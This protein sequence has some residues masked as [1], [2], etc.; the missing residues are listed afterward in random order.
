MSVTLIAHLLTATSHPMF[1]DEFYYLDCASHPDWGYVDQPPVSIMS[2][3]GW[4]AIAGDSL[5]A[6][7][8]L[9]SLAAAALIFL[10]WKLTAELGG[11]VF[12]CALAGL[13]SL[14]S[15]QQ[16][17]IMGLYSMNAFDLLFWA[18]AFWIIIRLIKTDNRRLWIPFGIV[19]GLGLMNKIGLLFLGAGLVVA[20]VVT[21]LRR[22]FRHWQFWAGGVLAFL[23]FAPY[24]VWQFSHDFATVEF[25]R[26]ASA[27]KNVAF[28]PHQFLIEFALE[29][30]PLT[31]LIWVSGLAVL[32]FWS[33]L[34][35]FRV[36]GWTALAVFVI[37][38]AQH[39]KPYYAA[40]LLSLLLATGS[41]WIEHI[42]QVRHWIRVVG[43]SLLIAGGI[44]LLPM[45]LRI[46]TPQQFISYQNTL[47]PPMQ[48][49]ERGHIGSVLPQIYGDSFGWE[50]LTA[51]VAGVY[52]SLPE[53][54]QRD[55]VIIASNYGEAGALNYYGRSWD[56]P[57]AYASQNNYY[58]WGPPRVTDHT[59]YIVIVQ[60]YDPD[61]RSMLDSVEV[62][63]THDHPLAM[64]Y[65]RQLNIVIGHGLKRP[66]GEVWEAVREFQ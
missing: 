30:N 55:C 31:S 3:A 40:G 13:A 43:V 36:L 34:R 33:A 39:G 53:D 5:F 38:M 41:V 45:G 46:L 66:I 42:T 37:L 47:N 9:S 8:F 29:N 12:A 35:P 25:V 32:L 57:L 17:A 63:A 54:D 26:N 2:L 14:I 21:P 58:F 27:F 22:H 51:A 62:A 6:V 10:T 23:I 64:N 15:P 20:M 24:V 60:T 7:R 65:E 48:A 19:M 61:P 28:A 52:H 49:S 18:A 50:E 1:R 59:T 4:R 11:G 44:L 56:L 16:R